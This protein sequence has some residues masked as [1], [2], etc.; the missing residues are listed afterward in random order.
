MRQAL[1]ITFLVIT[2]I[3]CA[4][5][6]ISLREQ[7]PEAIDV[8]PPQRVPYIENEIT[9]HAIEA[10]SSGKEY[11]LL[12]EGE[13]PNPCTQILR[14]NER[15]LIGTLELKIL[16]WQRYG[17]MC[18]EVITPFTFIYNIPKEQFQDIETVTANGT[19]KELTHS[20]N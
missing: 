17:E 20:S 15:R 9:I 5:S 2:C 19:V 18:A 3:S 12:I 13:F 11:A 14:V 4:S 7:H 6:H 16:G 8:N 10:V 1:I